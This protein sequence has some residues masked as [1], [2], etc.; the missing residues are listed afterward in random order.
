MNGNLGDQTSHNQWEEAPA[1]LPLYQSSFDTPS[2][3]QPPVTSPG[4]YRGHLWASFSTSSLL[5]TE[6]V[7]TE[8]IRGARQPLPS[9]KEGSLI[10]YLEDQMT[11]FEAEQEALVQDLRKHFQMPPD[12]S[13]ITFLNEHRNIPQLLMESTE[14]LKDC[15][16]PS[17]IFTLRAQLDESGSRTLYAAVFWS[18]KLQDVRNALD[19]FD[20]DWWLSHAGQAGGYLT[21]TYE[22]V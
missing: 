14:H 20:N 21:F 1:G 19:K 8:Q 18:G 22:L 10:P 13:V 7:S 5:S 9:P 16:G 2:P 17:T 12:S 15:F 3:R 11:T 4:T 6:V